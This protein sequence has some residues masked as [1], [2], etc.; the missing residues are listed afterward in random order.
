LEADFIRLA[1]VFSSGYQDMNQHPTDE[2]V[3]HFDEWTLEEIDLSQILRNLSLTPD[4]RLREHQNA[5]D[6]VVELEKAGNK[7]REQS[8]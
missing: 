6:L 1:D 2:N 7:L 5:L 4:Q 3:F 8:Q